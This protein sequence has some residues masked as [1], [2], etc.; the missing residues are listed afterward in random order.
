[1]LTAQ[2]K[3]TTLVAHIGTTAAEQKA[4]VFAPQKPTFFH[5][6]KGVNT[7]HNLSYPDRPFLDLTILFLLGF[8]AF[9]LTALLLD[10]LPA[11]VVVDIGMCLG[12]G[13]FER[14]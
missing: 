2:K 14:M 10:V 1:M 5:V 13:K 11:L 9:L 7:V 4:T 8:L 12:G 6:Q 3:A